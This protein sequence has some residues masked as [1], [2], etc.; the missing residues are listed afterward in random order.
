MPHMYSYLEQ[1]CLICCWVV[2]DRDLRRHASH[3]VHATLVA[4]LDQQAHISI[5][6]RAGHGNINPGI[7]SSS[8]R[9]FG[10]GEALPTWKI[11]TGSCTRASAAAAISTK[12]CS[13]A[14]AT[15]W[16]GTSHGKHCSRKHCSR[17]LMKQ[18]Q[19]TAV[20]STLMMLQDHPPA[21]PHGRR[22][23]RP[24]LLGNTLSGWF[25]NFLMKLKM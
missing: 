8:E 5:H 22:G 4:G 17:K 9:T 20:G 1:S 25:L 3:G 24:H 21:A 23:N 13:A 12:W 16:T 14:G 2:L 7:E 6:E 10:L 19:D 15:V 11:H 18:V